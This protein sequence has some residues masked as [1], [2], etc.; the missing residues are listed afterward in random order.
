MTRMQISLYNLQSLL[1]QDRVRKE[2][3]SF[4]NDNKMLSNFVTSEPM[5]Y[6]PF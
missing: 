6:Y 4:T 3:N 5:L 2:D 1:G